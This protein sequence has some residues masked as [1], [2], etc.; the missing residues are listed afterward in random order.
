MN[1]FLLRRIFQFLLI[2]FVI[3]NF[4]PLYSQVVVTPANML[5]LCPGGG[6]QT[7][8]DIHIDGSKGDFNN[9]TDVTYFISVPN[10][11]FEFNP[12]SP[13]TVNLTSS[14]NAVLSNL[15]VVITTSTVQLTYTISGIKGNGETESLIIG[16]IQV[17]A[18]GASSGNL[19]RTVGGLFDD[20][21]PGNS[22]LDLQN[23]GTL[24]TG[25][26]LKIF[27]VTGGGQYCAGTSGLPVGLDGSESAVNYN[28]YRGSISP[29]NL[30][31]SIGGTGSAINFGI[32]T[33]GNYVVEATTGVSCTK[34]M[35]GSAN[36]SLSP[37]INIYDL[38][39]ATNTYCQGDPGVVLTLSNSD[40]G[41]NY[42]LYES[43]VNVITTIAGSGSSINFGIR[44][45][46]SYTVV[47][48]N[49]DNCTQAMNGKLI[50]KSTIPAADRTLLGGTYCSGQNGAQ[51]KMVAPQ[52]GYGYSLQRTSDNVIVSTQFISGTVAP[53]TLFFGNQLV[54]TYQ[55]IA[56]DLNNNSCSRVLSGTT[57]VISYLI[58]SYNLTAPSFSYCTGSPGIKLTLSNS[59]NGFIYNL[60][61]GATLIQSY[62]GTGA[63]LDLGTRLAGTYSVKGFAGSC[64]YPMNGTITLTANP[65]PSDRTIIGGSYCNGQSGYN[66]KL[67]S[68]QIGYGYNLY[69]T[70]DNVIVSSQTVPGPSLPDTIYFGSQ[71]AGTYKV[72]AFD[73][74][75]YSCAVNLSGTATVTA[76]SAGAAPTLSASAP[77]VCSGANTLL[78]AGGTPYPSY[79][80]YVDGNIISG[81]VTNSYSTN[82]SGFYQVQGVNSGCTSPLSTGKNIVTGSLPAAPVL[83]PS[84]NIIC[85]GQN[86]ILKAA[87][88]EAVNYEFYLNGTLPGN[89]IQSSSYPE[90]NTT[91]LTAGSLILYARIQ[92][93]QGCFSSFSQVPLSV[94]AAPGPVSL[95]KDIASNNIC[96]K[97]LVTFTA[98][99]AGASGYDFYVNNL[100]VYSGGNIYKTDSLSLGA[101]QIYVV[102][103]NAGNCTV[104]S[105]IINMNVGLSPKS[106]LAVLSNKFINMPGKHYTNK[107]Y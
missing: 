19:I 47:A 79:I 17:K 7:L 99:S 3:C 60:Y 49:S 91:T 8:S 93:G 39:S 66:V 24:I 21:Q 54:G 42:T 63:A 62:P 96:Q 92:N 71:P 88:A 82:V 101:D 105:S 45:A 80:W 67:V 25:N 50:I 94:K 13:V 76:V 74:N 29:A 73:L 33:A 70:S 84:A 35:N 40:V 83:T 6:Y 52:L 75:N 48:K 87:S 27:N 37:A 44:P 104:T 98:S 69:R 68:P 5:T 34:T 102:A 64:S 31:V 14:K 53:D 81:A 78:T 30:V 61:N 103:K 51:V 2:F 22:P 56:F 41:I 43:D 4:S 26:S 16:G 57:S 89:Q 11:S 85:Q 18:V 65:P 86:Y 55:V 106:N 58:N 12:L 32:Q 100:L 95:I 46:G 15:L 28:L 77:A 38:Q 10:S 97:Q 36:V 107:N 1:I 90:L 20:I 72:T 59:D 23:H 9:G